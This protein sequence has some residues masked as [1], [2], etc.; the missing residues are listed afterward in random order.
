MAMA[1]EKT[2]LIV[3]TSRAE[4]TCNDFR[5]SQTDGQTDRQTTSYSLPMGFVYV[6]NLVIGA[7]VLALPKSFAKVGWLLG[8]VSLCFLAVLSFITVT[9]TIEAM[10]LANAVLRFNKTNKDGEKKKKSEDEMDAVSYKRVQDHKVIVGAY[11]DKEDTMD[12]KHANCV[13][14]YGTNVH[15]TVPAEDLFE[16]RVKVELGEMSSLFFNRTGILLYYIA[17]CL[18]LYGS[19]TVYVAIICKSLTTVTCGDLRA[20]DGNSSNINVTPCRRFPSVGVL[21]M[22][23][24][25]M[26]VF[27]V[28]ICP[29][30]YASDIKNTKMLQLFT[31]SYRWISMTLMIALAA[32]KI[33]Q[34]QDRNDVHN[35]TI[36][37]EETKLTDDDQVVLFEVSRLPSFLGVALYAFMCQHSIPA[38]TTPVRNKKHLTKVVGFDFLCIV[39]FY[40]LLLLT[41]IFAFPE[42]GKSLFI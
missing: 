35:M 5:G 42:Q 1:S 36:P 20:F 37:H 6:F 14:T 28:L 10:S 19:A 3:D 31:T 23:R 8:L 32:M 9:F 25:M 13:Q 41:A 24:V 27:V 26:S 21:S 7:G 22:Y 16:I 39:L 33:V 38:V 29:F 2:P 17:I 34:N 18:Y 4:G 11:Q 30:A 15:N 40:S 12:P